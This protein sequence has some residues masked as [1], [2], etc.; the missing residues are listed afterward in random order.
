M[1]V[2]G[3]SPCLVDHVTVDRTGLNGRFNLTL[4]YTPEPGQ[5]FFGTASGATA[6]DSSAPPTLSRALQEQLGLKLEPQTAP[7]DVLIIDHVERP[8]EN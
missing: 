5:V 7:V 8:P 1:E 4:K 6:P 3:L 2:A